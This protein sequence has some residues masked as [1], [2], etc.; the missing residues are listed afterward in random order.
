MGQKHHAAHIDYVQYKGFYCWIWRTSITGKSIS[1]GTINTVLER[2]TKDISLSRWATLRD[3]AKSDAFMRSAYRRFKAICRNNMWEQIIENGL[4]FYRLGPKSRL[5]TLLRKMN[6]IA[7]RITSRQPIFVGKKLGK[8]GPWGEFTH[9]VWHSCGNI[10]RMWSALY[11][12]KRPKFTVLGGGSIFMRRFG[13]RCARKARPP[14]CASRVVSCAGGGL[15]T[16]TEE[17]SAWT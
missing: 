4:W 9:R 12:I 13:T 11:D 10:L 7:G 6:A 17:N 1:R 8:S 15:L 2:I 16:T 5:M 3:S 14:K